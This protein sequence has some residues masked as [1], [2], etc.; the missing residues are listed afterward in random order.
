M[1]IK[2]CDIGDRTPV[3]AKI[4]AKFQLCFS[5]IYD[6]ASDNY[7]NRKMFRQKCVSLVN[8]CMYYLNTDG[9]LPYNWNDIVQ[10]DDPL[11]DFDENEV[12]RVVMPCYYDV[13]D[14]SWECL[15]DS[16]KMR[17]E[18]VAIQINAS[19]NP[20]EAATSKCKQKK[21][22]KA[23]KSSAKS[24]AKKETASSKDA[25]QPKASESADARTYT[26][27]AKTSSGERYIASNGKESAVAETPKEDLF[28]TSP[29]Y[30]TVAGFSSDVKS[31][32]TSLPIVPKRQCDIS[33]TTSVYNMSEKDLLALYPNQFVKTRAAVMYEPLEGVT[34][35]PQ[36]GLL[37]P[38]D[39]F[40][41]SQ[42]RDSI[43]RYPHIFQLARV[44]SDGS[45]R[46]F[47]NDI[48]VDGELVNTLKVW[49][50]LPESR[51]LD[52]DSLPS[53]K[54]RVEFLK[55]Y[56]IRRYILERDVKGVKH[57]HEVRGSLP[58]FLTLFMPF[59]MYK[60]EGYSNASELAAKCVNARVDYL[61]T[62][63]PRLVGQT[64]TVDDC[65]FDSYCC[66][67]ICDRSCPKWAQM[68]YLMMRNSLTSSSR[69]FQMK[70]SSLAKYVDLYER[71]KGRTS[72]VQCK[73]AISVSE[74]LAYVCVCNNWKGS[75]MR[76]RCY[77]L[78]FSQYMESLQSS[79]NSSKP[80]ETAQ[81]ADLWAKS[82]N[83]LVVSGLDYVNFKDYQSQ[84]VLQLIQDRERQGK[85]TYVVI[86]S[87]GNLS[88]QGKMFDLLKS[89]LAECAMALE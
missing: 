59:E 3:N 60:K 21:P 68:N 46:S 62:R 75:A 35:D 30:P 7:E 26:F 48:E 20:N 40:T 15:A 64:P 71:G 25:A 12:K 1:L 27:Q 53:N 63:N 18:L 14:V 39:G 74:A 49:K 9:N 4:K 23:S 58:E 80:S 69:P 41:D 17:K 11:G 6:W 72:A 45:L 47:Y 24:I 34:L 65:V 36:Y 52:L 32:H 77:H 83:D 42:V 13:D 37:L 88:G 82:C 33:C 51:I 19:E 22:A 86:P 89:K 8:A 57:K 56:A 73:D 43:I 61:R 67:E 28:I 31:V 81:Y 70:K 79:W 16:A 78:V 55:E 10:M 29:K 76:V 5:D 87:I 85:T 2:F 54:E 44:M 38:I 50:Y 84:L 66:A